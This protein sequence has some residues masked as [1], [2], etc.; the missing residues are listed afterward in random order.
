MA[1]N[2]NETDSKLK[3]S[4]ITGQTGQKVELRGTLLKLTRYAVV[5]EMYNPAAVLRTSEVLQTF[6]IVVA[7]AQ[8]YSG[9]SVVRSVISTGSSVVVCEVTLDESGWLDVG[10]IASNGQLGKKIGAEYQGFLKEW[11]K[12]YRVRSEFKLA[13]A[14]MQTYFTD[15]RLWLDQLELGLRA[16]APGEVL[17]RERELAAKLSPH[18][19]ATMNAMFE[20]FEE[21]VRQVEEDAR[22]AHQLFARRQLHPLLLCSPFLHRCYVKPLGYAGD[23]EMVNMMLRSPYEGASLFAKVVNFWFLQQ[24]P[25]EAHRNRI[26]YLVRQL[27]QVTAQAASQN[28]RARILNVACGPAQEVQRFL[29]DHK[30]SSH[31]DI[32]LLDFNEE[33]LTNSRAL[34]TDLKNKHQRSTTFHYIKKSVY[35]IVK[36]SGKTVKDAN[37]PKYDFVY[38][39]G[40]FDYLSDQVCQHMMN[41]MYDWLAPGGLLVSTNVDASN[42][43]RLTMDYV[44]AW[45]LIY[46][47]GAELAAVK[48]VSASPDD[49]RV[50]ADM[51]GVNIYLEVTKPDR[52]Q[53]SHQ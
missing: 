2:N 4:Y 44:M 37:Q 34:M 25:A 20:H 1:D 28:R 22:P 12:L 3:D 41:V 45:H 50:I 15:L 53:I 52:E 18:T 42:P 14:D 16:A 38:C 24:A 51:T 10:L 47:T 33:T 9:T 46:R 19:A 48:P 17:E 6:K 32:S 7:D 5:F 29:A 31:A 27:V 23:Y 36:E 39:A 8:L 30:I 49:C 21:T 26:D 13:L 35:N 11:Q 40:L 43:R